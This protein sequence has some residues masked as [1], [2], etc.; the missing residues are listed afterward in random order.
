MTTVNTIAGPMEVR[1]LGRTLSHEHMVS[2]MGGMEKIH[3]YYDEDT[4]LSRCFDALD[5]VSQAG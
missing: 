4:A 5:T 2:V 1:D 3:Q